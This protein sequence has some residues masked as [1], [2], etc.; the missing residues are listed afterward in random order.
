V[1]TGS[2][3]CGGV[4]FRIDAALAPIEACHCEQCR[5]AQGTPF[6][7]NTP[8][9]AEAFQLVK[10]AELLT[11][12]ES[13]PDKQRVFCC[14]CGSPIYSKRASPPE[15]YRVRVGLIDGP[16]SIDVV[17]HCY[18]AHKANWWPIRDT[19]PQHAQACTP[20]KAANKTGQA[21]KP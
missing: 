6:A 21:E 3:L 19:L 17:A 13:S 10:G 7:T 20:A 15:I 18:T 4:Q 14:I 8:I 11:A 9:S 1:H 16:L 12:F 2:C 5:K